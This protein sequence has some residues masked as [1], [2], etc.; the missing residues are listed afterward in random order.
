MLYNYLNFTW[1]AWWFS[2]MD[3][4]L[5]RKWITML[6]HFDSVACVCYVIET[7]VMLVITLLN[8]QM[9]F[10][11]WKKNNVILKMC[12]INF[13][14]FPQC[15]QQF[16]VNCLYKARIVTLP[17][18]HMLCKWG[19]SPDFTLFPQCFQKVML[20]HGDNIQSCRLGAFFMF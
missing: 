4:L 3:F 13:T 7:S 10:D 9:P 17:A 2:N 19:I 18:K 6:C 5:G 20:L 11:T 15:C 16:S 1:P 12:Y 14:S 8:V